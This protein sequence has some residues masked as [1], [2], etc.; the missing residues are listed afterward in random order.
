MNSFILGLLA[1]NSVLLLLILSG[2]D[3]DMSKK[4][5]I[6]LRSSIFNFIYVHISNNSTTAAST[7][8]IFFKV[9]LKFTSQSIA[10]FYNRWAWFG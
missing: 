8:S 2:Q 10:I 6:I 4:S 9:Q 7:N 1:T 3:T 5:C